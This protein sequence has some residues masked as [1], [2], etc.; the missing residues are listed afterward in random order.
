M[1]EWAL[2][3]V[4]VPLG[5]AVQQARAQPLRPSDAFAAFVERVPDPH[6]SPML[7]AVQ[8]VPRRP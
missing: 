7:R 1:R 8:P 2:E 4:L 5:P 3:R 6:L